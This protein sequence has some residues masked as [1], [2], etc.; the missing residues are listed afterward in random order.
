MR[1]FTLNC[2]SLRGGLLFFFG[3]MRL[4]LETVLKEL[5]SC[6]INCGVATA[7]PSHI[8]A[9]FEVDGRRTR[10]ALFY[11]EPDHDT[12]TA[13]SDDIARWLH[14]TVLE[15]YPDCAYALKHT[16][17]STPGNDA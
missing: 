11:G 2:S 16:G 14:D 4:N 9:W 13:Q 6:G 3:L 12:S 10:Q 8:G 1:G 15:L 5:Q 7:P 17:D